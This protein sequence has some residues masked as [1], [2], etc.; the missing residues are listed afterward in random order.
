MSD[1]IDEKYRSRKW[2][3]FTRTLMGA[4]GGALLL[5]CLRLFGNAN[6]PEITTVM[7]WWALLAGSVLGGYGAVNLIAGKKEDK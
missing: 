3:L 5:I 2:I 1:P 7:N 6:A 4:S